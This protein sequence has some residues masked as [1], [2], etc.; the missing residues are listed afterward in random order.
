MA[1]QI[2]TSGNV[3]IPAHIGV[4]LLSVSKAAGGK[5]DDGEIDALGRIL[6]DNGWN[7]PREQWQ[8]AVDAWAVAKRTPGV[9]MLADITERL[10]ALEHRQGPEQAAQWVNTDPWIEDRRRKCG[11]G[12][13]S[14]DLDVV[15]AWIHRSVDMAI[16]MHGFVY[17]KLST[18]CMDNARRY[19]MSEDRLDKLAAWLAQQPSVPPDNPTKKQKLGAKFLASRRAGRPIPEVTT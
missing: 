12:P 14:S 19:G 10:R 7:V 16:E 2:D 6:A 15:R 5:L 8:R 1:Y 18:E 17:A 3:S 13:E 4:V 9:S 11:L